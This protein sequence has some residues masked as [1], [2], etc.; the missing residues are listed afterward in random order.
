MALGRE[1][2]HD[3]PEQAC[4]DQREGQWKVDLS[5]QQLNL[6]LCKVESNEDDQKDQG[7]NG[8]CESN[9]GTYRPALAVVIPLSP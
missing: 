5:Y 8:G 4:R 2:T 9:L 7:D 3:E 1:V 6:N